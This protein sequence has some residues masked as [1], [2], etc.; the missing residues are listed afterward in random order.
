MLE[1][2]GVANVAVRSHFCHHPSRRI[3]LARSEGAGRNATA[4]HLRT[5][6]INNHHLNTVVW[7][8]SASL[9]DGAFFFY[10]RF[11]SIY[12]HR[13]QAHVMLQKRFQSSFNINK[14]LV[15]IHPEPLVK[16]FYF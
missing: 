16:I 15:C 1:G 5:M 12:L 9:S 10:P 14:Q 7:K 8:F 13:C 3:Q 2:N 6:A 4:F 11:I